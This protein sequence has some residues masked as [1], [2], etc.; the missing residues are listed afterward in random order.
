M[1]DYLNRE[2]SHVT[3]SINTLTLTGLSLMWG[4]MLGLISPWWNIATVLILLA[5]YGNEI[6]KRDQNVRL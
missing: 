2:S 6:R 1:P 3:G 5:G 4:T